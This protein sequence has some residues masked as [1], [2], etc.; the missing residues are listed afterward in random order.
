M[1]DKKSDDVG[2]EPE[3]MK[4][5]HAALKDLPPEE[6]VRVLDWLREKLRLAPAGREAG[7]VSLVTQQA[8]GAPPVGG[9]AQ[10]G[11]SQTPKVFLTQ[12]KAGNNVE[13]VTCLAYYL[14]KYRN[15]LQFKTGDLTKLN[16]EASQPKITN[17]S[18]AVA[19]ATRS[20]YL[21]PAGGGKKQITTRG[22]ALVEALPDRE[23]VKRAMDDAPVTRRRAARKKSKKAA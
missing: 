10:I 3:A 8:A 15:V 21:T 19:D 14:S 18:Q 9:P 6:Q 20:Q 12:K 5:T 7:P 17:P 11:A 1:A 23:Q 4:K 13:R 22:E 16:T 2:R